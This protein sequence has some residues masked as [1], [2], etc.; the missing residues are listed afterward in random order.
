[1][2]NKDESR[3]IKGTGSRTF[4]PPHLP[5]HVPILLITVTCSKTKQIKSNQASSSTYLKEANNWDHSALGTAQ[6]SK[7][8]KTIF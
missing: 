2:T 7:I 6:P 4:R 3:E 1:M 5:I 8:I